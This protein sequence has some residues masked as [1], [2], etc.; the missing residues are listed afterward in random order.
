MVWEHNN[1]LEF[2]GHD[3]VRG[4]RLQF[5]PSLTKASAVCACGTFDFPS[6]A[7]ETETLAK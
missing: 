7:A 5:S 6:W 3:V 1:E 4:G 2:S